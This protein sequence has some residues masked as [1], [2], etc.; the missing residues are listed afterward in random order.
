MT[1]TPRSRGSKELSRP[2]RR[3]ENA[4]SQAVQRYLAHFAARDWDALAKIL[5]DDILST[6]AGGS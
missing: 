3:L 1:S 4:A 5:A 6:I 2:A